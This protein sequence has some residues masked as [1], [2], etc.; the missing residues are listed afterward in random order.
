MIIR[1][2][3]IL[4]FLVFNHLGTAQ[5]ID[6]FGKVETHEIKMNK[7]K[8][9]TYVGAMEWT[10]GGI[11]S[12]Q[13]FVINGLDVK[14]PVMV[15]IISQAPDHN[16]DLSFHKK[17]WDKIE[18]KISTN[19]E[20]FVDK[21]FRTMNTAG[22]GVRSE[23][24]G[25]PYLITVKV[26]LQFPSTKPLIRLTDDKEEYNRH[27]MK[28]GINHS[29]ITDSNS[30]TSNSPTPTS[31]SSEN[32]TLMYVIIGLLGFIALILLAFLLKKKS[33]KTTAMLIIA[34]CSIQ[35]GIAQPQS[36]P[37]PGQGE[38]PVF[39]RYQTQNVAN[40]TPV[41]DQPGA[42]GPDKSGRTYTPVRIELGAGTKEITGKDAEEINRRMRER[43]DQFDQDYRENM[44]GQGTRGDQ[45]V[46]PADRNNAELNQLRR[47][48][49]ELQ[50][51]VDLLSQEDEAFEEEEFDDG[52]GGEILLYCE[53]LRACKTCVTE[54]FKKFNEHHAYF[55]FLQK[56]YLKKVNDLNDWIEYGNTLSSL[57][58]G[59]GMAWGPIL[60]HKVK[61]AMEEL[62]KAYNKKFDEY[63]ESMEADLESI[64]ACYD[65]E[66]GR[67]R[68]REGYEAQMFSVIN[69][70]KASRIHK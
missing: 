28:L 22:L 29:I 61:P 16:I 52:G 5:L 23:V 34:F 3:L 33:S 31:N 62:K 2:I 13:R 51:Q 57:P 19:G 9:G 42:T 38:S 39:Y 45:R 32:N 7:K 54:A 17:N 48:V 66:N 64:S 20:K 25:I 36:V 44:P 59:G 10:T 56:F 8:D 14:A 30:S 37:V 65:G 4:T 67:F 12:L 27:L 43:D 46:L 60:L 35:F 40:Q 15:R 58:G 24:A 49:R 69:A 21:I 70:L 63:I 1:T 11:D 50:R 6:L 18:S 55:E 47:Q 68:S 53:D 26:G 41:K